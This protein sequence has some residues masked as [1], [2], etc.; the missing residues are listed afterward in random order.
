VPSDP[1]PGYVVTASGRIHYVGAGVG[2]PMLLLHQTPRSSDEYHELIPL[3]APH[4]RVL[5]M[6][7]PG[8]GASDPVDAPLSIERLAEA[9]ADFLD[10]LGIDEATVLGHHTGGVI[11]IELAAS[12]PGRVAQLIVSATPFIDDGMRTALADRPELDAVDLDPDGRHLIDLWEGRR[13]MY[14]DDRPDLLTRFVVDALRAGERAADGHAAVGRYRMEDRTPL[15]RARTLLIGAT[16]DRGTFS[17]LEVMAEQLRAEEVA[18]IDGGT[19]PLMETRAA[20]VAAV[21]L[22]FLEKAAG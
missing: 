7:T 16:A 21:V 2:E 8:F 14:P 18:V 6:D 9:A 11:G 12:R 15:V 19:V 1:D 22:G 17:H 4:A 5:A 10:A 13:A 3:L 20:D